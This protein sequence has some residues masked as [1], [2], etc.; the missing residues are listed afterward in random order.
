[1]FSIDFFTAFIGGVKLARTGG[2]IEVK[3]DN[4]KP[5]L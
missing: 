3:D 5:E 2:R 4:E 1:M